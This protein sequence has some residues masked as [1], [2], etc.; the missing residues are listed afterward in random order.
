MKFPKLLIDSGEDAR[1]L[2]RK[3]QLNQQQFWAPLRVHQS[4]GSRYETGRVIPEPVKLL[5]N[6]VYGTNRQA[7]KIVSCLRERK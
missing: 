1:R 6:I 5:L 7:E 4:G 2:R 3:L